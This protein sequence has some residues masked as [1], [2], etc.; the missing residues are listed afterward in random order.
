MPANK[1]KTALLTGATS[2]IGLEIARGLHLAGWNLVLL[3]RNFKKLEQVKHQLPQPEKVQCIEVDLCSMNQTKKAALACPAEK[4]DLIIHNAGGAFGRHQPT[5]D[6]FERSLAL[7]YLAPF[8]LT[9]L[10]WPKLDKTQGCLIHLS[11]SAHYKGKIYWEDPNLNQ[12]YFI[13]KAYSQSKLMQLMHARHLATWPQAPACYAVHPGLVKTA[14]GNKHSLG[15]MGLIWTLF[16]NWRGISPKEG[17]DNSLWL[18]NLAAADRP[19]S[20]SYL[21][22]RKVKPPLALAQNE[23]ACTRLY[24]STKS[25]LAPWLEK[26]ETPI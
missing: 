13:L 8:L 4:L 9:E 20:G 11:S 14:I 16:T 15:Y 19:P 17:A 10:L 26:N 24:H 18:A 12:S 23:E 25:W 22:Q 6:G 3:S 5:D 21:H 2:G 7:N 1:S